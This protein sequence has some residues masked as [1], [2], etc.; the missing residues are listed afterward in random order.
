MTDN[1]YVGEKKIFEDLLKQGKKDMAKYFLEK[2]EGLKDF[3]SL[4][5]QANLLGY[6]KMNSTEREQMEHLDLKYETRLIKKIR[7]L[8]KL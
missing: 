4:D 3:L 1:N 2:N 8:E 6:Q 5:Y 7:I